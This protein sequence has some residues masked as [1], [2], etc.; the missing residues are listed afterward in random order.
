MSLPSIAILHYSASPVIGGVEAVID[1]H[2]RLLVAAGYPVTVIAGRGA[3]DA[4]PA[5][6]HFVEIAAMDTQHPAILA[7]SAQLDAGTVPAEFATLTAQLRTALEPILAE[8]DIVMAHN[9]LFKHFNL[10]LTA[11]LIE[12]LDASRL[13]RTIAWGHDFTWTSPNSRSKVHDGYPWDLLR[14]YR[15][16]VT[17]VAVSVQRQRELAE[18]LDIPPE[19]IHVVYNGV[20]AGDLLGLSAEGASL[21]QRLGVPDAGLFLLMPVRVTQAK[22]IELALAV[23][24]ELK[25]MGERPLLILTGPPDPHDARSMAYFHALQR[26]RAELGVEDAMRFVYESGPDPAEG[27][28]I[29]PMVVGDLYRTADVLFMP[30]HREGFGMP[31]L[32]A[33]LAGVPVAASTAVPAAVELAGNSALFFEPD[34][35]PAAVAR[36]LAAWLAANPVARLRRRTRQRYTWEAIFAHDIKP[37][38]AST[39]RKEPAT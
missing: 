8:F 33:G 19:Q 6:C 34:E 3:A 38:L 24:A 4:L 37:L 9:V 18:L 14:T 39:D 12:L 17:Y 20:D 36:R 27:Y 5:G 22:N 29:P 16:E 7:A 1:A 30:S 21:V 35:A 32:E 10:P 25:R 26:R 15:R 11:A 31:V 2:V 28:L 13:P 23:V